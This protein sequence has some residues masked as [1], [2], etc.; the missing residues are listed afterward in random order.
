MAR[1]LTEQDGIVALVSDSR[2]PILAFDIETYGSWDAL[3]PGLQ[4][5]LVARD[6]KSGRGPGDPR[7]AA[8]RVGL[9]PGLAQVI[10][11]GLWHGPASGTRLSLVPT[12]AAA[13]ERTQH[14]EY[15]LIRFREEKDLLT[16]FWAFT[17]AAV[18][19]GARLVTFNG[20]AFDGPVLSL[21]SAVLG[22]TPS[23]D[24]SGDRR[25]T[26]PH[27]D[28]AEVLSFF[29]AS[30]SRYSLSYWCH[31]FGV[32]S[33]K[34]SLNGAQVG[35]AYERADYDAISRYALGDA[36]ATG[37]IFRRLEPTL[38]SVLDAN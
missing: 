27:C 23:V 37:E 17:G 26:R 18:A 5:Y 25:A 38:L 15:E 8:G 31:V 33:P 3:A 10:A 32:P 16:E 29:G 6:E 7:A 24:L 4:A 14:G 9:L 12:L 2:E 19:N 13:E 36:L 28:L 35:E 1:S 11:V 20:R 21:R 34:E 30:R 22:V